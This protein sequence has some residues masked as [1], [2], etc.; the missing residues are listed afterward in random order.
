ME[1]FESTHGV[2]LNIAFHLAEKHHI[3]KGTWPGTVEDEYHTVKA[4]MFD[5]AKLILGLPDLGSNVDRD[6]DGKLF[7]RPEQDEDDMDEETEQDAERRDETRKAKIMQD[8]IDEVLVMTGPKMVWL[9]TDKRCFRADAAAEWQS[10]L[11]QLP[12]SVGW[13]LRKQS[14]SSPSNIH[15]S[16]VHASSTW[17]KAG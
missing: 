11:R 5:Q 8:S 6:D 4:Q 17:S 3:K 2:A 13:S 10:C 1:A 12:L 9:V 16:T 15:P 14:S 7:I